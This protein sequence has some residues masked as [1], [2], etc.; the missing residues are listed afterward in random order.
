M[1][2]AASFF[3]CNRAAAA[4]TAKKEIVFRL[5]SYLYQPLKVQDA[6]S[7]NAVFWGKKIEMQVLFFLAKSYCMILNM[8]DCKSQ[9][10]LQ[11]K[12]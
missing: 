6:V 5:F 7:E 2:I 3:G 11:N 8:A 10:N 12:R 9:T 4:A 1:K